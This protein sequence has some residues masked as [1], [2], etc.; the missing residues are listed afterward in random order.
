MRQTREQKR[1]EKLQSLAVLLGL[2]D[3]FGPGKRTEDQLRQEQ[4]LSAQQSRQQQMALLPLL[5]EQQQLA[6]RGASSDLAFA[7]EQR[8]L[9]LEQQ[10]ALLA[11]MGLEQDYNQQTMADR[12]GLVGSQAEAAR[13]AND[14]ERA[15]YNDRLQVSGQAPTLGALQIKQGGQAIGS[16]QLQDQATRQ[17]MQ[18][19]ADLFPLKQQE[20]AAE[21]AYRQS[22]ANPMGMLG[23]QQQQTPTPNV[24]PSV[25]E[26]DKMFSAG[27]F[28]PNQTLEQDTYYRQMLPKLVDSINQNPG[29]GWSPQAR[30]V[31]GF[32]DANPGRYPTPDELQLLLSPLQNQ[33][34]PALPAKPQAPQLQDL[35][36]AVRQVPMNPAAGVLQSL[37]NR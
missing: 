27:M 12:V 35:F 33:Q 28:V 34:P 8:P 15:T 13:R 31:K 23:G 32:F 10:R 21:I 11:N 17:R 29:A 37:F 36:N 14:F 1:Q 6:N 2:V 7:D 9:Q 16:Q 24:D 26:M 18:Q 25:M 4:V 19:E 3:R 30:S 20:A 5:L 22:L